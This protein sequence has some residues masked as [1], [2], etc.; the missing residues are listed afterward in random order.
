MS[1]VF[2]GRARELASFDEMLAHALLGAGRFALIT[3]ETGIGKSR[4]AQEIADDA[5]AKG[6]NT[7]WGRSW[8][9]VGTP[10]YWPWTQLLR[11]L[12][13]LT[14]LQ[15]RY[16]D[17][18]IGGLLDTSRT[19]N[20]PPDAQQARFRLFDSVSR[21]LHQAAEIRP[22]LLVLDDIHTAD[23]AT[24]TLLQFV[25]RGLRGANLVLIATA[26]DAGSAVTPEQSALLAQVAREAR[27]IPLE[28]LDR[29]ELGQWVARAAPHL[30]ADRVWAVSEGNPLF[31]EELL[32]AARKQPDAAWTARQMPLGIREAVRAH[33]AL[34]S[35]RA[36][37]LLEIAS[38]LG[39]EPPLAALKSLASR[40]ELAVLDEAMASGI[41]RDVGDGRLRF[42]HILLRDELYARL[43]DDRRRALHREASR[44][45]GDRAA[46]AHHAL[47][48][49]RTKDAKVTMELVIAAMSEAAGRLAHEDAARLGQRALE[50]LERD[51]TPPDVCTLLVMIGEALVVAGD[52]PAGQAVGGKAAALAG[53]LGNAEL[54][55]RAAL[56]RT[57]EISFGP[58]DQA[59]HWLRKAL[60]ALPKE[61]SPLRTLVM[62]RL[63]AAL[64]SSSS[65]RKESQLLGRESVAMGRRLRDDGT[66]LAALHSSSGYFPDDITPR[67]RFAVYAEIVDLAERLGTVGRIAPLLS[68]HVA[69][70]L[71]LGE[72]DGAQA[73]AERA[74]ALLEP[75]QQPHY[76][77]RP[78]LIR[79]ALAA[80]RGEFADAE[81][82]SRESLAISREHA[83]GEGLAMFAIFRS[84]LPYLRGD[85]GGLAEFLPLIEQALGPTTLSAVFKAIWEAPIGRVEPVQESIALLKTLPAEEI[86]G[87]AQ[88]GWVCARFGLSEHAEFFYRLAAAIPK[89]MPLAFPP[90]GFGCLGPSCLLVGHLAAMTGRREEAIE[91]FERASATARELRSP[92]LLAN[93]E[94]AWAELLAGT[95][96]A[97]VYARIAFEQASS[98][99]LEVLADKARGLTDEAGARGRPPPK[100][101]AETP[102]RPSISVRREG[103]LWFIEV[104]KRRLTLRDSKGMHFLAALIDAPHRQLHVLELSELGEESDAGPLL[105]QKT[106]QA[107]RE[108][109]EELRFELEQATDHNDGGRIERARQELDLLG[110]ELTRALG[111]GG[112]D[113][114]AGSAAERARINVQRRLRDVIRRVAEQDRALG[115]HLELSVNTGLFCMYA[116]TWPDD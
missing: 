71:E 51:L 13:S 42:S 55:A 5:D 32:A 98:V 33:L 97:A 53:D 22:L 60:A 77:W 91:C 76:R 17:Q 38:V 80:L 88:L 102:A 90:G 44:V 70:W 6:W 99:G 14:E 23:A 34:V 18:D 24:L 69:S 2:V 66:L 93:A 58:D 67:E 26:R 87:A 54:L 79:A 74:A 39:R 62:G 4:L 48:G 1:E 41:L 20:E 9:G 21:L 72:P 57:A 68:W 7:A 106:K 94:L 31:V 89:T 105:D 47:L 115:R 64:V 85:D 111:L 40:D 63:A 25:A 52:L 43:G 75:Y 36:L 113:R 27:Q 46:A 11:R 101:S 104:G 114:R 83:I 59:V 107:Y 78:P 95:P 112:R 81:R 110:A 50:T 108:R 3:G 84:V 37:R 8:E 28:R 15:R 12:S 35:D 19:L 29:D 116:P 10:A 100:A 73:A 56:T 45:G 30:E 109:A 92:P 103:E 65:D 82:W 86:T 49:T 96:E 16:A 61:D